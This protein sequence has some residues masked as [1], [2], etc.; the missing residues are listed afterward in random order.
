MQP[1]AEVF[2]F[3]T[4]V[5][6]AD[7]KRHRKL[8]LCPHNNRVPSCT[9]DKVEDPLGVCSIFETPNKIAITCP[10]RFREDWTIAETAAKFFFPPNAKWTALTE[11]RLNEK[12]GKSAGNIDLVLVSIDKSGKIN[13]FG[14]V[15]IQGVYISGNV[16]QPFQAFMDTKDTKKF[17][18]ANHKLYPRPDYLSSSRKR[19]APQ[20]LYK[21]AILKKWNKKMAVVLDD[22]FFAT[23]PDL[24]VAK[25]AEA[26]I[27]WLVHTLRLNEKTSRYNLKLKNTIHTSFRAALE[28]ISTPDP[29]NVEDFIETLQEKLEQKIQSAAPENV[30]LED[31]FRG[32]R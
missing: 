23:L 21:G 15:E 30:S 18:W 16:R 1:L 8:R 24:P 32:N 5:D 17:S 6:S 10:V 14:A 25:P 19:L 31:I 28:K 29:G 26:D 4:K 20:L 22:S 2:G 13:D 9:K 11:V 27:A 7:A 3:P 12:N